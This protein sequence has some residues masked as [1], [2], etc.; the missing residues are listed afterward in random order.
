MNTSFRLGIL[1]YG[2]G[3]LAILATPSSLALEPVPVSAEVTC[4]H[5]KSREFDFWIGEWSINNRFLQADGSWVDGGKAEARLTPILGGCALLE[6]WNGKLGGGRTQIGFSLRAY[7]PKLEKWLL[8]L[9][10]PG[11]GRSSFGTLTGTFRHGRGEFFSSSTNRSGNKTLTRYTF[12]D[13]LPKSIRWDSATSQDNGQS[14]KTTWIMEFSR[15]RAASEMEERGIFQDLKSDEGPKNQLS[16]QFD[17]LLGDWTGVEEARTSDGSWAR[18]ELERTSGKLLSGYAV[19]SLVKP[20]NPPAGLEDPG[21]FSIAA[22]STAKNKWESW[23]ADKAHQFRMV[24]GRIRG[25]NYRLLGRTDGSMT[26]ME[27][28][29]PESDG[30]VRYSIAESQDDGETWDE[31]IRRHWIKK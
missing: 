23:T 16:N 12:S 18:R 13:A 25:K 21:E 11:G 26:S 3:L 7:D 17:F 8:L 30:S 4:P 24:E 14:W 10:W 9:N 31:V 19:I 27:K 15:T 29:T 5:E 2:T 1:L 20:K 28:W 22:F 6:Q